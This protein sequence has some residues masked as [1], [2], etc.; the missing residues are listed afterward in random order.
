[1]YEQ[2]FSFLFAYMQIKSA[3]WDYAVDL[4]VHSLQPTNQNLEGCFSRPRNRSYILIS[5]QPRNVWLKII[6][7]RS[8]PTIWLLP[9]P[10]HCFAYQRRIG[11]NV[12][13]QYK[14]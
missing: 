1:M 6:F 13:Y 10:I 3:L 9:L 8:S 5:K 11:E 4:C 7:D 2:R 12:V 14:N